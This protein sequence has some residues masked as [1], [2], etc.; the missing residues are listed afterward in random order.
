MESG[1]YLCDGLVA[2]TRFHNAQALLVN[3]NKPIAGN[4][5]AHAWGVGFVSW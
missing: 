3:E 1:A 5:K 4:D 2:P